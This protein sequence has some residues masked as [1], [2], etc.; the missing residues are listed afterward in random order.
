MSNVL[1]HLFASAKTDG[2]DATQV[3]PSNW[4]AGHAFSGGALGSILY[5]D[6]GDATYGAAWLA[7]A[8]GVLTWS[9]AG[10]A[11]TVT[12]SPSLTRLHL[13]SYVESVE[14]AEPAAPSANGYRLFAK[15]NGSGKTQLMVRFASGA[16]QQI[17]IE[18]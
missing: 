3:Q 10:V 6:T 12:A 11:P 18:P 17:A 4:N 5:R 1:A 15:D 16:S 13:S 2:A 7:G 8:T 14:E 9:G